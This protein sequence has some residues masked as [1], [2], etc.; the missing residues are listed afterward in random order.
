VV[1]VARSAFWWLE[2]YK[3]FSRYLRS[4]FRCV[5]EN[6]RWIAFDLQS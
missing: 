5:Q 1:V 4:T 2:Y 6:D 3:E